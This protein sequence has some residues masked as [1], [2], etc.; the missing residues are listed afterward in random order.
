MYDYN[1]EM[2]RKKCKGI[3]VLQEHL[4]RVLFYLSIV[5]VKRFYKIVTVLHSN[6]MLF[7]C[8]TTFIFWRGNDCAKAAKQA[9]CGIGINFAFKNTT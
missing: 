3:Y 5:E 1:G 6:A 8:N 2:P 4:K 9:K 7:I